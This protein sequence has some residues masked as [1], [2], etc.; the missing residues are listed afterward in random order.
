MHVRH[1]HALLM[2]ALNMYAVLC[3]VFLYY[4]YHPVLRI[5]DVYPG[6]RIWVFSHPGSRI[7][8]LGSRIPDPKKHGEVTNFFY[9]ICFL[10]FL[11]L[12]TL[13]ETDLDS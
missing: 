3:H 8:D 12:S 1:M 7:P 11:Q 13:A 6:S 4:K 5:R 9:F 10:T 2:F